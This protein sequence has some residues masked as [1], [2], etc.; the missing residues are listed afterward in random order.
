MQTNK[1]IDQLWQVTIYNI[2]S[3]QCIIVIWDVDSVSLIW[4]SKP[5]PNFPTCI[6]RPTEIQELPSLHPNPSTEW[7]FFY[8]CKTA[9]RDG[10]PHQA[11]TPQWP[12][13]HNILSWS[14]VAR[15][16]AASVRGST[17]AAI[18][19]EHRSSERVAAPQQRVSTAVAHKIQK[20]ED[21]NE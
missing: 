4:W 8:L 15:I 19:R 2:H 20:E 6:Y 17:A 1:E 18:D 21:R 12:F 16:G 7:K 10:S 9:R 11:P 5:R 13:L 14:E 3:R